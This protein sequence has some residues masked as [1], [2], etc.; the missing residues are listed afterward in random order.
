MELENIQIVVSL[1]LILGIVLG[2]VANRTQ[3]CTMGAV[4]DWINMGLKG[5]IGAWVLAMGIAVA[6]TQILELTGLVEVSESIYRQPTL[7]LAGY[8]IG[9]LLFGVGMT[10]SAG[11]GQRTLVRIGGGNLKSLVVFLVMGITAYM[12][13]RGLLGVIRVD[14]IDPLAI[15]LSTNGV[16]DQSL[17]H[18]VAH[19]TGWN[20]SSGLRWAMAALVSGACIIWAFRQPALR[21][22]KDNLLAGVV[23]GLIIIAAWI[24]TGKLGADD[25]D[26]VPVEGMSF[27]APTGNTLIYLMTY[28]GATINF[29][30][31]VVF[32]VI[33]GSFLYAVITR[34][35]SIE[36]FV[37]RQDMINH[38]GGAVMM[39]FGGVLAL[40]CTIGQG[41]TGV[42]TLAL[43][44][45]IAVVSIIVGS[46]VAMRFQYLRLNDMGI[47]SSLFTSIADILL[48]WRKLA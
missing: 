38:L 10:L 12:T 15:D 36:T 7:G 27:V 46:A 30:I 41:V 18:L 1:G 14:F 13:L 20:L 35:F 48:P 40:G 39:G 22:D 23:V 16:E 24:V 29:G 43:G 5:R 11:C 32:G 37:D 45:V 33:V 19:W 8:I 6:G 28:T 42:S 3:F 47:L 17:A 2:A 25:F 9:G 31:A 26:P 4:S 44:S 34:S 21:Q